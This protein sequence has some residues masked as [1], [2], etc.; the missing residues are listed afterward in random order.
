M[1]DGS[2]LCGF[3]NNCQYKC[4][5]PSLPEGNWTLQ[6]RA[7]YGASGDNVLLNSDLLYK[8][9]DK[10]VIVLCACISIFPND[11]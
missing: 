9:R 5:N 4:D 6:A 2:D 10:V 8:K 11:I 7:S 3:T 1:R